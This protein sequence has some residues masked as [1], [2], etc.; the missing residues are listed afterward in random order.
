MTAGISEDLKESLQDYVNQGDSIGIARLGNAIRE[1]SEEWFLV[2]FEA[3]LRSGAFTPQWWGR[4]LYNDDWTDEETNW[5]DRDLR[6]IWEAIAPGRP[7][8]LDE[9]SED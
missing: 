7:Y 6:E 1:G 8:P 9:S 4:V 3:A 2:E 5:L